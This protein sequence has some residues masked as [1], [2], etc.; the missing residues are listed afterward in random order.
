[1]HNERRYT[2][3]PTGQPWLV[4]AAAPG[5]HDADVRVATVI[6]MQHASSDPCSSCGGLTQARKGGA[7]TTAARI[8]KQTSSALV[9]WGK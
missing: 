2:F 5:D 3:Y 4:L 8:L 6:M 7:A 1:M 9:F